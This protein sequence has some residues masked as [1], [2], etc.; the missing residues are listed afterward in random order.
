MMEFPVDFPTSNDVVGVILELCEAV[1][2]D[3]S[4][5]VPKVV[6]RDAVNMTQVL[7]AY[8]GGDVLTF[9][10]KEQVAAYCNILTFLR[11]ITKEKA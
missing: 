3:E 10:T 1:L 9:H 2:K 4:G 8:E 5:D 11:E 6:M 7:L